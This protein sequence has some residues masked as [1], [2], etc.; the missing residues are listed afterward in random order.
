VLPLLSLAC[1][2]NKTEFHSA[3]TDPDVFAA[4]QPASPLEGS[5]ESP[6][7]IQALPDEIHVGE[8]FLKPEL[9]SEKP[10]LHLDTARTYVGITENPKDSN[11]GVEVERF[12]AAVGLKPTQ[13]GTG[14]WR[15]FPW[16]AAF[17]SYCLDQAGN[18][19]FPTIRSAGAR[20]FITRQSIRANVVQRGTAR[21][22]PGT[23]VIW[24]AKRDPQD[25]SGHIGMVIDWQGQQGITVEGNTVAGE[26]GDQREGGGV[27]ERK[28]MLSPGNAFRIVSFTPVKLR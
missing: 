26:A 19:S 12:L 2:P 20:R 6:D 22:E 25:P 3:G 27:F 17:V 9:E 5:E 16:C 4:S 14:K 13:D 18:V 8:S 15:S 7:E 1:S 23:L 24:K 10:V 11:R 28:R 21:I